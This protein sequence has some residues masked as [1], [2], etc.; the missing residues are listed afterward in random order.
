MM[1]AAP[2]FVIAELVELLD[3]SEVAAE[4]QHRM[5]AERVMRGEEGSELQARH[6]SSLQN[7]LF[8]RPQGTGWPRPRQS[9]ERRHRCMVAR[10]G[11]RHAATR[12][13]P[14][15]LDAIFVITA[16]CAASLPPT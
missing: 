12:N 14:Q 9:R 4:L 7:F 3:K 13:G 1:L 10:R 8:F 2:E 5:L 11:M 6:G 15:R 16:F